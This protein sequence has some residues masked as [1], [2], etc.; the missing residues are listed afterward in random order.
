[1]LKKLLSLVY[2]GFYRLDALL[3]FKM[4]QQEPVEESQ[5]DP[6]PR[7]LACKQCNYTWE[8]RKN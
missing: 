3:E 2:S 4:V 5:P 1:M 6:I 7:Q 8:P